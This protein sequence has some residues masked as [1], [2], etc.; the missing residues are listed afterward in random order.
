M[1]DDYLSRFGGIARL[2]GNSALETFSKSHVMVIGLG[3]VGSWAVEALARS[4]VGHLS[5][6]DLDDL[7]QTNTNRQIHALTSTV[8][9]SKASVLAHRLRE[10]NPTIEISLHPCFYSEKNA[11]ALL[12]QNRPDAVIDAIDSIH[13]KCH[14]LATCREHEI[15]IITSGGAGGRT[16]ASQIRIDDLA[17]THGDSL[18]LSVR[19]RLRTEYH[20]PKAENLKSEK[21]HIPAI[22]SPERPQFPQCDGSVS[23]QRPHEMHGKIKC[24]SGYGA[25]THLT[26]TFGNLAAGWIL[27]TLL[28]K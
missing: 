6:V 27:P 5:L 28:K 9:K 20:F 19:K 24:D 16:D 1:T 7:C 13:Q 12:L 4:G 14:L 23:H 17:K 8:G 22:F 3:G 25:A 18:L 11:D 2:Y 15:P 10:I 26:A 21:F